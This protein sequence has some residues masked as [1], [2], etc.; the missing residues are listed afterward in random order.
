MGG[1]LWYSLLALGPANE[2]AMLSFKGARWLAT[3]FTGVVNYVQ[4]WNTIIKAVVPPEVVFNNL[5]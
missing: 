1:E 3:G 4:H 2:N 5:K